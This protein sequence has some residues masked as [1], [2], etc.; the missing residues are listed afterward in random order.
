MSETPRESWNV[1]CCGKAP[2]EEVVFI[3]QVVTALI[4]IVCGLLNISL[5]EEHTSLWATLVSGAVGY[6][7]PGPRL[8]VRSKQPRGDESLLHDATVEFVDGCVPEQHGSEIH[9]NPA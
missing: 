5:T 6:L 3:C 1:G 9:D 4:V 8:N 7:L 2:K